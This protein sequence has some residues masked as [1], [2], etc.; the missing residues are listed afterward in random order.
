[1]TMNYC[2]CHFHWIVPTVV[3]VMVVVMVIGIGILMTLV[4]LD[5]VQ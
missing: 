1:M 4:S 5:V 2:S 3:G